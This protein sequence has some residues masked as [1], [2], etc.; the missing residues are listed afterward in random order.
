MSKVLKKSK[1]NSTLLSAY[2]PSDQQ[3]TVMRQE[4]AEEEV[5]EDMKK[6]ALF[7]KYLAKAT[8]SASP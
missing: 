4:S 1:V 7:E 8:A 3:F 6:Q 5:T 2:H